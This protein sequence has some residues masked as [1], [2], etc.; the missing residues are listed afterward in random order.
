MAVR[1]MLKQATILVAA[2]IMAGAWIPAQ[3]GFISSILTPN[4]DNAFEDFSRE[5]FVDVNGNGV[6]DTGDVLTGFVQIDKKTAPNGVS[7]N[8]QIY[9]IFSIQVTSINGSNVA[10]G[11]TTAAGLTLSSL[12]P[13][14]GAT[15]MVSVFDRTTPFP[16]DLITTSPGDLTGNGTVTLADYFKS[17]ETNGTLELT[18]GPTNSQDFFVSSLLVNPALFTTSFISALTFGTNVGTTN[19]ATAINVNNLGV[20]LVPNN[21]NTVLNPLIPALV[22]DQLEISKGA[23][24]GAITAVNQ[25]EWTSAQEFI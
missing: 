3:A 4:V 18:A 15:D 24:N 9:A 21:P 16:V 23:I 5:A 17:I 10:F 19:S 25:P 7:T 8:N 20:P 1:T 2:G 11:P 14:A 22:T 6:F 13:G 12:V